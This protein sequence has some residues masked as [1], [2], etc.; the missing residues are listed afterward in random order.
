MKIINCI[1]KR[2]TQMTESGYIVKLVSLQ[3]GTLEYH[4]DLAN[5][6]VLKCVLVKTLTQYQLTDENIP[7]YLKSVI[8]IETE[9][10]IDVLMA[11]MNV[12]MGS[13]RIQ[14]VD[15]RHVINF[16]DYIGYEDSIVD[17]LRTYLKEQKN[18][19]TNMSVDFGEYYISSC[20]IDRSDSGESPY[21]FVC[22]VHFTQKAAVEGLL[23]CVFEK[24]PLTHPLVAY[25]YYK[26]KSKHPRSVVN[27]ETFRQYWIDYASDDLTKF[28]ELINKYVYHGVWEYIFEIHKYQMNGKLIDTTTRETGIKY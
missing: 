5:K 13:T 21:Q 6:I 17:T 20:V 14:S 9:Y 10:G 26:D 18:Y 12:L 28:I 22:G 1:Y 15:V 2:D 24:G 19:L 27:N 7:Q 16:M 25:S 11:F 4:N 3:G 23:K 8:T